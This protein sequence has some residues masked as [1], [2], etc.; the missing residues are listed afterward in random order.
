M[1]SRLLVSSTTNLTPEKHEDIEFYW[2]KTIDFYKKMGFDGIDINFCYLKLLPFGEDERVMNQLREHAER[3]GICFSFCHLPYGC[4]SSY[5]TKEYK[6]FTK[7][8][9]RAIDAASILKPKYSVIHPNTLTV[10]EKDFDAESSFH[11]TVEYLKPIV[12]YGRE[13]GVEIVVE[14]MRDVPMQVPY[15]RY[16]GFV[17]ELI[18]VADALNVGICWD[19]GHGN[20]CKQVQSESIIKMGNRL[21][22]LH[23]HDNRNF[24]DLHLPPFY[25]DVDWKDT[26][27]G[28]KQIGYNGYLNFEVQCNFPFEFREDFAKNLIRTAE[29]FNKLLFDK[30]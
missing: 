15:H 11:N 1:K 17:E 10:A 14:N 12:E 29:Y 23:I 7:V 18:Q 24:G 27:Q 26:M 30:G 5:G 16:C 2:H 6:D 28:L 13:K 3:V 20:I 21:K 8:I 19:I 9:R 25:G 22:M 4:N